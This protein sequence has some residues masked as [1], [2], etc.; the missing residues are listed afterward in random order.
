MKV[1]YFNKQ[2]KYYTQFNNLKR[3][4]TTVFYTLGM[5]VGIYFVLVAFTA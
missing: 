4:A 3:K 5:C 2:T 1:T